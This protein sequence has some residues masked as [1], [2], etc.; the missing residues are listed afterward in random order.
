MDLYPKAKQVKAKIKKWD[1]IKLAGFCTAKETIKRTERQL[2]EWEKMFINNVTDNR[3]I[4]K[5]YKQLTQ[6]NIKT[7]TLNQEWA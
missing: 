5:I 7:E 6:L 1:L 2:M 4:P 3:L